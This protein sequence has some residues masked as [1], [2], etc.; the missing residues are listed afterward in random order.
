MTEAIRF[1]KYEGLG[2]DFIVV[3][4]D[5]AQPIPPDFARRACDRHFGVGADG[6]LVV[7]PA[8]S[9]QGRARMT[10]LNADGSRPEMCGNGIRCVALHLARR[11]GAPG[12]SYVIDTDAGPMVCEVER[13]GDLAQVAAGLGRG[14]PL[15]DHTAELDGQPYTF[16]RVSMGN[17]HAILFDSKLDLAAIDRFGPALNAALPGGSNVEFASALG[18][19]EFDLVVWERGVGRTLACG[20][21]A[22]ALVVAA[23]SSR[24]APFGEP[25]RVRLPGGVL[26]VT[27]QAETL[28]VRQ[29]GPARLVFSGEIRR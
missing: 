16:S 14:T 24:R 23:A 20:T 1:S 19:R 29:R 5:S 12:I 15:A 4:D 13:D 28:D 10:V 8:R 25:V 22:G 9:A 27:V 17:P 26:E 18:P 21:G 2:N 6:V 3:E 11:D 7:G